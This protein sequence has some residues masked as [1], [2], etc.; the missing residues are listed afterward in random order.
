MEKRK[1]KK[2]RKRG[3]WGREELYINNKKLYTQSL[4]LHTVS[5]LPAV[6]AKL[7]K[8]QTHSS[9]YSVFLS[10][11]EI[12]WCMTEISYVKWGHKSKVT[13]LSLSKGER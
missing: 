12:K 2:K 8:F 1:R 10:T 5:Y 7:F 4:K 11:M 13:V 6:Y 3:R 9:H